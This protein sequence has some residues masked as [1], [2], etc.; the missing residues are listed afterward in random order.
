[1]EKMP[2]HEEMHSN[3]GAIFSDIILGGQDGLVNVLGIVLGLAAATN[4]ARIVIIAGLAALFAESIAMA[5]VAFTSNQA[6]AEFYEAEKKRELWEIK[7][8]PEKEKQ[9]VKEIFANYGLKGKA[10]TDVV[11]IITSNK[12]AW[13]NIMMSE[14]LGLTKIEKS[15]PLKSA[16]VVGLSAVAGSLVPLIPF[17]LFPVSQALIVALIFSAIVLFT[18]G[19]IKAKLTGRFWFR[20]GFELFAIG[21]LAALAGY[22]VGTFLGA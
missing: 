9:E 10:L 11:K 4:D 20:S 21:M 15:K 1:M 3:T 14:E 17:Y 16:I 7:N 19:A 5:A 22:L 2:K 6:E 8:W 18:T 13:L 12:K